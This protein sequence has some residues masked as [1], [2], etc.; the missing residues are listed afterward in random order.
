MQDI[1]ELYR[2]YEDK[3]ID[4]KKLASEIE[5]SVRDG[6]KLVAEKGVDTTLATILVGEHPPSKL[7]V[8][9]KHWAC[10]RVGISSID[11]KLPQETGEKELLSLIS[12]LNAD[13]E[14][15]GIL[16]QMPLPEHINPISI[17]KAVA[18]GKDV[19]GFHP[20]NMGRLMQGDESGFVPCTPK[21]IML[22]LE[23]YGID[24]QGRHAVVVG[25]SNIVGKPTAAMLLNRNATLSVCHV[26]TQNLPAYTTQADILVVATGVRGLIKKDMVKKGAVVFDVGITWVDERVHGDVQFSEVVDSVRL[27]SPVPGGVGPITI[28]VLMAHTLKAASLTTR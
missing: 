14:V 25:H 24:V 13:D 5:D 18:P 3:V 4:G 12:E 28:A 19:D 27:I 16:V 22:A 8:K 11:H 20:S 7:Y 17:M 1:S 15:H 10:K 23:R 26:Y 6:V 2:G 21:G 9:L